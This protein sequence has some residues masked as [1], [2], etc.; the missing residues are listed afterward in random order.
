MPT[1]QNCISKSKYIRF[2]FI[3]KSTVHKF[4]VEMITKIK[5]ANELT[6]Y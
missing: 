2:K 1:H 5:V 6:S 4:E 3:A